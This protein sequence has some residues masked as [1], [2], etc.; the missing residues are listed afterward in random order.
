MP[1]PR[2]AID[3]P[4]LERPKLVLV[5]I[6]RKYHD[7]STDGELPETIGLLMV[8]KCG[9]KP[10]SRIDQTKRRVHCNLGSKCEFTF[11]EICRTQYLQ[12]VGFGEMA[13][14]CHQVGLEKIHSFFWKATFEKFL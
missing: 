1:N 6:W 3:N 5:G 12:L 14:W 2:I 7:L 8:H 10:L 11:L 9:A 13:N 4:S